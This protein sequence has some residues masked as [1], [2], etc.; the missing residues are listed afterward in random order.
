MKR[1]HRGSKTSPVLRAPGLA[2]LGAALP[3]RASALRRDA[4][5][6]RQDR[7]RVELRRRQELPRRRERPAG[8]QRVV[9]AGAP[10][11]SGARLALP[12]GAQPPGYMPAGQTI[13]QTAGR[14]RAAGWAAA[15]AGRWRM[16]T[17]PA[18]CCRGRARS[19]RMSVTIRAA[20]L[21]LV[22][23]R[24]LAPWLPINPAFFVLTEVLPL[25]AASA[26][27]GLRLS[28]RPGRARLRG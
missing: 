5:R 23:R 9:R 13:L 14:R 18:W 15:L 1:R 6:T 2:G 19:G 20:A 27:T 24:P 28:Q 17:E 16:E 7:R 10:A 3:W 8:G 12:A 4:P 22:E 21:S 25:K 26:G 11:T